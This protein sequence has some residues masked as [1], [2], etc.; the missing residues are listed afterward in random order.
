[1]NERDQV[2]TCSRPVPALAWL[3]LTRCPDMAGIRFGESQVPNMTRAMKRCHI[4]RLLT[5]PSVRVTCGGVILC[6]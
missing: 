5:D 4:V 3:L 1:M 2:A 6:A